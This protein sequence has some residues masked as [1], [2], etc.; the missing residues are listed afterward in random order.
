MLTLIALLLGKETKDVSL[1]EGEPDA[2]E[3][4]PGGLGRLLSP[5]PPGVPPP[6][7][8]RTPGAPTPG[9]RSPVA[10]MPQVGAD[11]YGDGSKATWVWSLW[12]G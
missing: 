6:R 3:E 1:D 9:G 7:R 8:D 12:P 2:S 4:A 11:Q 5:R 10:Q